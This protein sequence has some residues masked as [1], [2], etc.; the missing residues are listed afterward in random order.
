MRLS[1]DQKRLD[2]LVNAEAKV[3][4]ILYLP[5]CTDITNYLPAGLVL[6]ELIFWNRPSSTNSS[7]LRV[8][9]YDKETGSRKRYVA[10]TDRDLRQKTGLSADQ[11]KRAK[12][13]LE[14]LG[15]VTIKHHKFGIGNTTHYELHIDRLIELW[16]R[17]KDDGPNGSIPAG[18]GDPWPGPATPG[19]A[20]TT[21]KKS[22]DKSLISCGEIEARGGIATSRSVENR[23]FLGSVEY[24]RNQFRDC[25]N[26]LS[27][28]TPTG[29]TEGRKENRSCKNRKCR[30]RFR[31]RV[32]SELI[33]QNSRVCPNCGT[34][35]PASL[36]AELD[37]IQKGSL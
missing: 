19:T 20:E 21:V 10:K 2:V 17:A 18:Q 36:S 37:G 1:D 24:P 29:Q 11:V 15:L 12:K 3:A 33:R 16:R 8:E 13:V 6:S 32:I 26:T 5:I 30:L 14:R 31:A 23:R 9:K 4:M 34:P 35:L 7:K 27:E 25:E 28:L 22:V